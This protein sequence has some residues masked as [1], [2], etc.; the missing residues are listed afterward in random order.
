MRKRRAAATEWM[1]GTRRRVRTNAV[2]APLRVILINFRVSVN[3]R[4]VGRMP[5]ARRFAKETAS[6]RSSC[7]LE[8]SRT[9]DAGSRGTR[10]SDA[11]PNGFACQVLRCARPT[12][13]GA[14][15][16]P[17]SGRRR[18]SPVAAHLAL[19]DAEAQR[20]SE[21]CL[22]TS[23]FA[24]IVNGGGAHPVG[25]ADDDPSPNFRAREKRARDA[26]RQPGKGRT[27]TFSASESATESVRSPTASVSDVLSSEKH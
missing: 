7:L 6:Y 17:L 14:S 12:L 25:E 2:G 19:R 1:E 9:E 13:D 11:F 22:A 3:A 5:S 8:S 15:G 4:A 23:A 27:Q 26:P 24:G 21:S 18:R 20:L 16:I 10:K